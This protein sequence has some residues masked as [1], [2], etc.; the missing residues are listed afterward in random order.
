MTNMNMKPEK[1]YWLD[2]PGNVRKILY[3]LYGL[4]A[5]L[6]LADFVYKKETHFP[7]EGWFGFFGIFGLLACGGV[8]LASKV[9]RVFLKREEDY[10]D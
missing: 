9:L 1:K 10:Y 3:A 4:W 7:V 8:I 6:V 2:N 5:L